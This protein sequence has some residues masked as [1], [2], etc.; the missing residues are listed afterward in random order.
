MDLRL[1]IC[2]KGAFLNFFH[3]VVEAEILYVKLL[4]NL[5]L[6]LF[7]AHFENLRLTI[8]YQGDKFGSIVKCFNACDSRSHKKLSQ[9]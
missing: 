1:P 3:H 6:S 5:L 2:H 7:A 9:K 4:F 8:K